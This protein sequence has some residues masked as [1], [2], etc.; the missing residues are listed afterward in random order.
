MVSLGFGATAFN[1]LRLQ[2]C[3]FLKIRQSRSSG[4]CGYHT[5]QKKSHS[6]NWAVQTEF[7]VPKL[8]ASYWLVKQCLNRQLS[9]IDG[10]GLSL[11]GTTI[12]EFLLLQA[13][14]FPMAKD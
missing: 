12:L 3:T 7:I 8:T 14:E 10:G 4:S 1:Y 9:R 2:Y 13:I 5:R 6:R 11:N